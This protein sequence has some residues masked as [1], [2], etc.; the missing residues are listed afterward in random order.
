MLTVKLKVREAAELLLGRDGGYRD[1]I[2]TS[3]RE[4]TK[5]QLS[6]PPPH[7]PN[8]KTHKKL[9]SHKLLPG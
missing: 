7:H 4:K 6:L 1:F 8:I 5:Y 3:L 9:W 2:T